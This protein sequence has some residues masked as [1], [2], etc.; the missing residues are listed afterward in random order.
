MTFRAQTRLA[1]VLVC[2]AA[3]VSI[4]LAAHTGSGQGDRE[5]G[6]GPPASLTPN[7]GL[8]A[9]PV[10]QSTPPRATATSAPVSLP[11]LIQVDVLAARAIPVRI[12]GTQGHKV[13]VTVAYRNASDHLQTAGTRQLT[14]HSAT[15]TVAVPLNA[16]ARTALSNCVRR[17][18]VA[19]VTGGGASLPAASGTLFLAPPQ[20]TQFFGANSLWDHPLP[21]NFQVDPTSQSVVATLMKDVSEQNPTISIGSYS[22]A[23]YTV[24]AWQKKVPYTVRSTNPVTSIVRQQFAGGVPIPKGAHASQGTDGQ[25][26]VWQPA[27]DTMWELYKARQVDG[28]WEG[29]WGAVMQH[30]SQSPGYWPRQPGGEYIST[31]ASGL[32]LVGGLITLA[33][34]QRRQINHALE[35]SVPQARRSVYS[36]PAKLTDGFAE[37]AASIPEGA[38]FRLPASLNIAALHLPPLTAMIARA[39]QRYGL[40]VIDQAGAVSFRG[41]DPLGGDEW[42]RV[43]GSQSPYEALRSFPWSRLQLTRMLLSGTSVKRNYVTPAGKRTSATPTQQRPPY[44]YLYGISCS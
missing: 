11:D 20:C 24:P 41:Q 2:I 14:L 3:A 19:R 1:F 5:A 32:P 37:G 15:Q 21:D 13:S 40:I 6:A 29:T 30:V 33:D 35:I 17:R 27:T 28:R 7:P 26:T 22:T 39:A 31:T 23:I 8:T 42:S 9:R 38:R 36:Q 34:L 25:L 10:P 44:C 18:I 4:V 12:N 16:R 43:L